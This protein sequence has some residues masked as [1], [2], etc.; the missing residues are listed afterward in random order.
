MVIPLSIV[1]IHQN[2]FKDTGLL[3]L[4]IRGKIKKGMFEKN[5][6]AGCGGS[7]G[8]NAQPEII[9]AKNEKGLTIY[10]IDK[11]SKKQ[12]K[13]QLKKVGALKAKIKIQ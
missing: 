8:K 1:K 12:L 2:A 10:V 4:R 9:G 5:S 13:K 3:V 7:K 11:K 6:L